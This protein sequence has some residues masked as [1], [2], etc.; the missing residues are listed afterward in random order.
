MVPYRPW[1]GE[2]RSES[3][4][5]AP[6]VSNNLSAPLVRHHNGRPIRHGRR[7]PGV[8]HHSMARDPH[9]ELVL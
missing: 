4:A 7:H 2:K 9:Y 3:C 8:Y 6:L 1:F 5:T